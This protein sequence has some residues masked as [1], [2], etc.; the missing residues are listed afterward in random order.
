MNNKK[1]G[2]TPYEC[3][4]KFPEGTKFKLIERD[5]SLGDHIKIGDIFISGPRGHTVRLRKEGT[6]EGYSGNSPTWRKDL[7][8]V[9]FAK[10]KKFI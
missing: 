3:V 4:T 2:L 9:F 7:F 6:Y 8:E 10:K 5:L 1:I